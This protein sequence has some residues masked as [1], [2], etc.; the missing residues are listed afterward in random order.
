MSTKSVEKHTSWFRRIISAQFGI[1][2]QESR[3]PLNKVCRIVYG[4]IGN[5]NTRC[6][7]LVRYITI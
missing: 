7:K 2:H 3:I 5:N 4:I 1:P 6:K